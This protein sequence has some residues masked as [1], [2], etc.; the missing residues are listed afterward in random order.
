ME[1]Q[2]AACTEQSDDAKLWLAPSLSTRPLR[3]QVQTVQLAVALMKRDHTPLCALSERDEALRST[4][5]MVVLFCVVAL[6]ATLW[7]VP[8]AAERVFA[9]AAR[10]RRSSSADTRRAPIERPSP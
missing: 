6:V 8:R 2:P 3:S 7:C 5:Q 10:A 4:I 1:M 9:G